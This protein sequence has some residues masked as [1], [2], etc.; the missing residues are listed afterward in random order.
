MKPE[1]E[2][3]KKKHLILRYRMLQAAAAYQTQIVEPIRNGPAVMKITTFSSQLFCCNIVSVSALSPI[4][5]YSTTDVVSAR[6]HFICQLKNWFRFE[7]KSDLVHFCFNW[8]RFDFK[9]VLVSKESYAES[10]VKLT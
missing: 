10:Q 1:E 9:V 5:Y 7:V 2:E 8:R 3:K 4:Q 6:E